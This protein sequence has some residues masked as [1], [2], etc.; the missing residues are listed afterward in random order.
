MF[1]VFG[2]RTQAGLIGSKKDQLEGFAAEASKMRIDYE[3]QKKIAGEQIHKEKELGWF[4]KRISQNENEIER[5]RREVL[6]LNNL[7]Q[8]IHRKMDKVFEGPGSIDDK[9][10]RNKEMQ[11][12]LQN[13]TAVK[14]QH[15]SE[16]QRLWQQNDAT[17]RKIKKL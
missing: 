1:N 16:I 10:R 4:E 12:K 2:F 17:N 7:E 8:D 15:D 14:R 3:K 6:R 11:K 13:I 9:L 5:R